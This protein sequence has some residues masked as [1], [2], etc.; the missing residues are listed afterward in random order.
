MKRGVFAIVHC[1]QLFV[2]NHGKCNVRQGAKMRRKWPVAAAAI[3]LAFG[4]A[5]VAAHPAAAS[6]RAG[7]PGP[8]AQVQPGGPVSQAAT[9]GGQNTSVSSSNWAG[10]AATGPARRPP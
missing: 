5:L 10:Y 2:L 3:P 9:S 7:L 1:A 6:T 4:W 8:G